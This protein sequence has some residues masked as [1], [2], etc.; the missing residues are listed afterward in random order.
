MPP[1][2]RAPHKA[3]GRQSLRVRRL[4]LWLV[5]LTRRTPRAR[6]R[7]YAP[8]RSCPRIGRS[9][10]KLRR[11]PLTEYWRAEKRVTT[12][13]QIRTRP[14]EV[15]GAVVNR[16]RHDAPPGA[17]ESWCRIRVAPE[18][19]TRSGVIAWFA[20]VW[21]REEQPGS[22][23]RRA[24]TVTF[25]PPIRALR[26]GRYGG[27]ARRNRRREFDDSAMSK[28][29]QAVCARP[30]GEAGPGRRQLVVASTS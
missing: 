29:R 9:S 15:T 23:S 20:D 27:V 19:T 11:S 8:G 7:R 10:A 18:V 5:L 1:I 6:V 28:S 3:P 21:S 17:D 26:I 4:R 13:T 24:R 16:K 2:S 22:V 30:L 25:G 12:T 14:R